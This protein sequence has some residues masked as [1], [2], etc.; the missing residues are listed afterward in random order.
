MTPGKRAALKRKLEALRAEVS[1]KKPV[2]IEP[3]RKGDTDVGAADEDAQALTEMLQAIGS[4][5]NKG[6]AEL[7]ARIEGAL[8]K[9]EDDPDE[10]GLCEECG[11][12]I[13]PRRLEL[14][15]HATLCTECQG[16]RDPKRGLPRKK[17]T[18]YR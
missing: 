16:T 10:F 7:I 8:R 9:L 18:D 14:M 2:R 12:E 17:L 6:Q 4:Q 15:P 3:S 13:A 11:D 1:G 5:R